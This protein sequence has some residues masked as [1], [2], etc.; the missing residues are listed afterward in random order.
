M[1]LKIQLDDKSSQTIHCSDK[2]LMYN[3]KRRKTPQEITEMCQ[4]IAY[5][6]HRNY[7]SISIA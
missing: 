5:D 1:V 2:A 6:I 4:S 7:Q 3:D